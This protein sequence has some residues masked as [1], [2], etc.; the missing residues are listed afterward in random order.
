MKVKS[1]LKSEIFEITF[2]KFVI[3]QFIFLSSFSI[4]GK[5]LNIDDAYSHPLFYRGVDTS[6]GFKTR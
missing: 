5:I 3:D 1:S 6:T 2:N 4:I